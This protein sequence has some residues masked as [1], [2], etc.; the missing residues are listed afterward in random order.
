MRKLLMLLASVLLVAVTA[1]AQITRVTG[2]VLSAEDNDPILGASVRIKGHK[3]GAVT[4]LDGKF[5]LTGLTANDKEIEISFV[6]CETQVVKAA[7]EITVYLKA[8]QE[9]MDEL[10]VVAFGKQ[11][12]ESFTG[13]AS[14]VN[15]AQLSLQQTANPIEALNGRVS[16]MQ[17]TDANGLSEDPTIRV[18][19]TS[20]LNAGNSPL[21]VV[22]GMPYNGYL[23][24]LNTADIE[25][26]TV[27][28]DAASNALYGA[29]GANGVILITTKSGQRG[30]T[31]VSLEAKWG[32]NT[33]GRIEYNTI[34]NP[35]E[36]YEA[37]Y[38]AYKNYYLSQ[39]QTAAQAHVS[40]NGILTA[41]YT[42]GGLGYNVYSVPEN[43][44]LIGTNGKLNPQ[45]TLGN[46]VAYNNQIY[47]L[48]PDDWLKEGTRD[49]FRQEY[50]L[51][52]T[53]GNEMFR[54]FASLGYL[55]EE[56]ISYGSDLERYTARLKTE[57]QAY[58]WLRI[59]ANAL[60]NHKVTNELYSV[61]GVAYTIAPIYPLYIRDAE[62]NILTDAR[63]V[64]YDYGETDNAGLQRPCEKNTNSI[65]YDRLE[66]SKNVSNAFNI[67]GFATADLYDGLS[68]T[69]NGN[70]YITENRITSA[71][72][73]YYGYYA[74]IGGEVSTYHY[75]TTDTN[76]QQLLNYNKQFG[77]HNVS[78]LLGHEYSRNSVT[79]LGATRSNIAMYTENQE[80]AG[81]IVDKSMTGY[82]SMYN[83][84]GFFLRAQY[85]YDSK[86]FG[87]FSFRRDG[88]SRFD[89]DNRWGN[90]WSLG[91][92]YI[93]SREEWFPKNNTVNVLKFKASYGEQG[94]DN[95]GDYRYTDN[96]SIS[97]SNDNVA[98]VFSSKGNK[99]ITWETVGSLNVGVEFE[100]FK[101]RLRGSVEYYDRK[102][103]D[104]LM[105]FSAPYSIGYG[106]YYSNVGD[107]S[108]RGIEV[109]LSADII[110]SEHFNW[111]VDAN[112]AWQRNRVT[113]LPEESSLYEMDGHAGFL[114]E[115]F[116][117]GEGLPV[118]TWYLK[119]YA[120]VD[121]QGQGL[122][123]KTAS[124]GTRITTTDYD[125]A[126]YYLCGS[127]LPDVLGGFS[128]SIRIYD[129]DIAA[130]FNYSLGGL[131]LDSGYQALMTPGYG[132]ITGNAFH[133]DIYKSWSET[134]QDSNIP[135][136]TYS[137]SYQNGNATS[138]RWLTSASYLAFKNLTIGYTLP[139]KWTNK[140]KMDR[141]RVY[142]TGQNLYYWTARKGFDPRASISYGSYGEYS[143]IRSFTGGLTVNF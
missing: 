78:G 63:G 126:D 82:T 54:T 85:D 98:Y 3:T 22:D 87:S 41:P 58:K 28:K 1:G 20:S 143:P 42:S 96:Y 90:F 15:S 69:V 104:M 77:H 35:G 135:L 53:G 11:K 84:E 122:F 101:S 16:G 72:D 12:R 32:A 33:N 62:G 115:Y 50:N 31:K 140:L 34:D 75:R 74:S 91:G 9:T 120:G 61:F 17:M 80:L 4:D 107:M 67:N 106:G 26:I 113:Y 40:A 18:R 108:N 5:V 94:N 57:Y 134:N 130:N 7:P 117:V 100:L 8:Q 2:Q 39:G 66:V 128:T 125:D 24:D 129:F 111:T 86:Y 137:L 92:A 51:S 71:A 73:P 118:N 68:L 55:K 36:Y 30:A 48:Y 97:N 139:R 37:A 47:T 10:I 59:G 114:N 70:V 103:S 21:I 60:Y 127:S 138:D 83:V 105:W 136:W 110:K 89:P 112:L 44:Y 141:L 19:G 79:T 88:S 6:G 29:R 132:T 43:Q 119:S 56:G 133:R 95:I 131:K 99:N 81:A 14:V 64:R 76:F 46:R 27:L 123:Y 102:T 45:A 38:L 25:N 65:Q 121:E 13:S 23:N 49:G 142:V 52:L 116:Y 124:D 109:E 93:I